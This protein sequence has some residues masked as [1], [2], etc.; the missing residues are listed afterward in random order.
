MG[1]CHGKTPKQASGKD[2][3]CCTTGKEQ[4]ENTAKLEEKNTEEKSCH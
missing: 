4:N 1:C 2:H 3:K